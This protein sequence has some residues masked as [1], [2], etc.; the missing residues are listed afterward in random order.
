MNSLEYIHGETGEIADRW[1]VQ[2]V[3]AWIGMYMRTAGNADLAFLL[4][5]FR[6]VPVNRKTVLD[7]RTCYSYST[8]SVYSVYEIRGE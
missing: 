8:Q 2:T 5:C 6:L 7:Q 4:R 1:P 3:D